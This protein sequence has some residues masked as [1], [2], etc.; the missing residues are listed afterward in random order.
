MK[1]WVFVVLA[2]CVTAVAA[3]ASSELNMSK[4]ET[5][6]ATTATA[7]TTTAAKT[8]TT[9]A[10]AATATKTEAKAA[11]TTTATTTTA[12]KTEVKK[13]EVKADAK[14]T[15]KATAKA[16]AKAAVPPATPT[17]VTSAPVNVA[18]R[19]TPGKSC[20]DYGANCATCT[21]LSM[22][23]WSK[24]RKCIE[25]GSTE[26]KDL[27]QKNQVHDA[28]PKV[29]V[30][31]GKKYKI[32]QQKPKADIVE[33]QIGGEADPEPVI[34]TADAVAKLPVGVAITRPGN[35]SLIQQQ[36]QQKKDKVQGYLAP[37]FIN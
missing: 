10:T 32:P 25:I 13:A 9:T 33:V 6:T 12:A 8:T 11:T 34:A 21:A 23:A 1:V 19:G 18:K 37:E 7:T 5:T 24:Q 31:E 36:Q 30:I 29:L 3:G 4:K 14:A 20:G 35:F 15:T 27:K 17:A 22:C 16:T 26:Y 2:L 28:C